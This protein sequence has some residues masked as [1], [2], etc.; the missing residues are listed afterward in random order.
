MRTPISLLLVLS[1]ALTGLPARSADKAPP[2]AT[3]AS[4]PEPE[5]GRTQCNPG[6]PKQ[7][8]CG[9]RNCSGNVLSNRDAHNCKRTAGKSWHAANSV[10]CTN[11]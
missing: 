3:S 2:P 7:E 5:Q 4:A 10:A 1:L 9:S 11:L 8:C 6:G